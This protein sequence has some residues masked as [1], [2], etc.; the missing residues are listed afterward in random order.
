MGRVLPLFL[1][2]AL[3]VSPRVARDASCDVT[4]VSWGAKML[5]VVKAGQSLTGL[6]LADCQ[7]RVAS[8]PA[9]VL[10]GV[11]AAGAQREDAGAEV[12]K[13]SPASAAP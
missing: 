4:L 11:T 2:L 9:V 13:T 5:N 12:D 8:L 10:S 3:L 7:Q 6:S 1:L